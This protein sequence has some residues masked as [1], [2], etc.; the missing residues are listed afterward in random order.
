MKRLKKRHYD[1]VSF[2]LTPMIDMTMLLLIFFMVT[3]K[4][5]ENQSLSNIHLPKASSA[6]KPPEHIGNRDIINVSKE[7]EFSLGEGR[8]ISIEDLKIYLKKKY[9]KQNDAI[10]YIRADRQVE[11]KKIK[12]LL[13]LA[14]EV[15]VNQF[16]F[17]SQ[18]L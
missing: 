10:T 2:Q 11:S 3:H 16:I 13:Q 18:D 8:K 7:G 6:V 14:A 15:G 17:A 12:V 4:L 9:E 5:S 1:E